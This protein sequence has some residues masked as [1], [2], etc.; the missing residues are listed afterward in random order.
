VKILYIITR[1]ERGGAQVHLLDL[2]KNLPSYCQPVVATGE[3]GFMCDEARRLG[4]PV[5]VIKGLV[6]PLSP[7][8]DLVALSRLVTLICKE[9][10]D[11]VNAHTSK[12]GLLGR[13]ASR[14]TSTPAVFTAHTWSFADGVPAFQR[15]IATPLER[16]AA[17]LGGKIITV[18]QANRATA[19]RHRVSSGENLVC[20]WNGIPD[21]AFRAR[22]GSR[23][24]ITLIT[25]ARLVPQKDHI[26]LL[27]SLAGLR[28]PWR[29][30][31][32]GD[33]PNRGQ[34]Q[35]MAG[36][37]GLSGNVQFLGDRSDVAQLLSQSDIFVL[38]SKWEGLPISILEAMR[39]GLPVIA[40]DVGGVAECV[41]DGVT[42]F[43]V[44]PHDET[45]LRGAL[46]RLI[47]SPELMHR[48]GEAGRN[49]FEKN[50][51]IDA[52]VKRT[53]AVYRDAVREARPL[54]VGE[55]AEVQP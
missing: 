24:P 45:R 42:G 55:R 5:H 12:A 28:T 44:P 16:F 30:L 31:V 49:R 13:L 50:F 46:A 20:I 19:V 25:V 34:V 4:I 37:L 10:P 32:V 53:L 18:S 29:L 15:W 9:Q 17:A 47:Q 1:A 54:T 11:L 52:M 27:E 8:N 21:V 22:P 38:P 6:Q 2:L 7:L 51:R 40:S 26:L 48:M 33:G 35:A 43:L 14:L 41:E 39:A 23:R 36:C 3:E